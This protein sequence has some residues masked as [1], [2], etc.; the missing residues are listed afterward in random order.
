MFDPERP[1]EPPEAPVLT[2]CDHCGADICEGDEYY[3][4]PLWS[5]LCEDCAHAWLDRYKKIAEKED[6][7]LC[8][9]PY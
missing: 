1:L 6:M 3:D 2:R 9:S 5:T 8:H 4:V 7:M